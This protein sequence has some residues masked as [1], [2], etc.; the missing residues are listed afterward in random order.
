[1]YDEHKVPAEYRFTLE[2]AAICAVI[3][4]TLGVGI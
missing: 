3:P 4:Y 2:I 1:M